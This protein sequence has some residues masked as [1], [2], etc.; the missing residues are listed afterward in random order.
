MAN[1]AFSPQNFKAYIAA[2]STH[3][4]VPTLTGSNICKALDVDSIGFP[5][6][7]V[8]Q[9]MEKRSSASKV[10]STTE[11]SQDNKSRVTEITLSGTLHKDTGHIALLQNIMF[12]SADPLAIAYSWTGGSGLYGT[13]TTSLSTFTLVLQSPDQTDGYNIVLG[14]CMCTNFSIT[15]DMG[16]DGGVY[17]WSATISTGRVPS[18]NNTD[19][20]SITDYSGSPITLA[21]ASVKKFY[22]LSPIMANFGLTIDSPAVY[23][24]IASTG[25]QAFTRGPEIA[26]TANATMK[27]DS[28]T[29]GLPNSFDTQSAHDAADAFTITQSTASDFSIAMASGYL[30]DVTYSEGDMMMIDASLKAVGIGSGNILTIDSA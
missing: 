6:L 14:G 7:N 27:L 8:T 19:T 24:G 29:R 2:E 4:T 13:T 25:Y 17:K 28:V 1:A 16:T 20:L 10:F 26:V 12:S 22:S 3:G 21:T 9:V 18:L 15:A 11:F 5:A 23:S 30:T